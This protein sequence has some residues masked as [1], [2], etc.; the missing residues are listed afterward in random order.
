M[1]E[2]RNGEGRS[3]CQPCSLNFPS[4]LPCENNG[5]RFAWESFVHMQTA[6]QRRVQGAL[7]L[8]K[9]RPGPIRCLVLGV[10]GAYFSWSW[11][12]LSGEEVRGQINSELTQVAL[13]CALFV[14]IS[15]NPLFD[16][17]PDFYPQ[18]NE[19]YFLAAYYAAWAVA[20]FNLALATLV[21]VVFLINFA[22]LHGDT[23][24][25]GALALPRPALGTSLLNP[26][27]PATR[28]RIFVHRMK[29]F[30][31][32]PI[33]FLVLGG[34][35]MIAGFALMGWFAFGPALIAIGAYVMIL[36]LGVTFILALAVQVTWDAKWA[37]SKEDG[38]SEAALSS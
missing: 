11:E 33:L 8:P 12:A 4:S 5:R 1:H 17:P 38:V 16:D 31:H 30:I 22:T 34:L 10:S 21:A 36:M 14:N 26:K 32:L 13:V 15:A 24:L 27:L 9:N 25:C 7:T 20:T 3:F 2:N 28:R 35:S 29:P 6:V 19:Q 37:Q 23:E 18:D